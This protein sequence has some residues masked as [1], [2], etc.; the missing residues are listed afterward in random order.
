MK[1]EEVIICIE[2]IEA[3]REPAFRVCTCKTHIH[4]HKVIISPC[5]GY[6]AWVKGNKKI[7]EG[8]QNRLIAM[9]TLIR[10][11]TSQDNMAVVGVEEVKIY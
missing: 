4:G 3:Y 11:I 9:A 7:W 10:R 1:R 5:G 2:T 8:D 6:K